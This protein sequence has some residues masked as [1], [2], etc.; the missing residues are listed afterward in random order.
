VLLLTDEMSASSADIFSA[1]VQDNHIASLFGYRTMGAGGSPEQT[2]AGVYSEGL[3]SVT[4]SLAV[5]LQPV[6][7]PDY[8][9]TSYVENV[10]VR[11]DLPFD[12]MTADNLG[13]KA[14]RL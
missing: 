4:R 1:L 9:T 14:Q 6:V 12:Y 8:P 7:T 10:G 5:R 3:T 13:I 11:P 2:E